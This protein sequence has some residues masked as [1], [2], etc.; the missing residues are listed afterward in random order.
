[1]KEPLVVS[2]SGG[3]SS[4]CMCDFLIQNYSDY[5]E[6]YFLFANTGR[7]HEE[8]LKFVNKCDRWFNLNVT[9]IEAVI[10]PIHGV[11]VRHKIVDFKT[12]SRDGKP[13]KDLVSIEGIPNIS[14]QK[15][16]DYLKTQAMRSYMREVGLCRRGW[17]AKTA[18]GMRADEPDRA[19]MNKESTK[20]FNLV[21]PL[22]HWG[23]LDKQDVNTFWEQMPFRLNI[24]PHYGNCLTCFKKSDKKLF[25]IAHEHPEW[26]SWNK[27]MEN[28]Y[29]HIKAKDSNLWWRK[30]RTTDQLMK[31]ALGNDKEILIYLTKS[32]EDAGDGCTSSCEAFSCD[33]DFNEDEN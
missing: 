5:Y 1:M 29:K 16:S 6:F 11:G 8:T 28:K 4:G 15:C 27:K 19:D 18:I 23:F 30:K 26:F 2:F 17:S 22:C 7:E 25:L 21:Y 31:E 33:T 9:W 3:E 32:E 13:F 12:V 10:S 24:P 14:R 20:R